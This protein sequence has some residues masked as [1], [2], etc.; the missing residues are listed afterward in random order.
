MG[1]GSEGVGLRVGGFRDLLNPTLYTPTP[2]L[3]PPN[4]TEDASSV[5]RIHCGGVGG[6]WLRVL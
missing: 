2:T 3:T 4:P 6:W 5:N 1:I